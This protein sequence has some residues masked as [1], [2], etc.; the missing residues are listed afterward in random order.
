MDAMY[1]QSQE[2]YRIADRASVGYPMR[3]TVVCPSTPHGLQILRRAAE[4][5]DSLG[6]E[7]QLFVPIV[8]PYP[9]PLDRAPVDL[10]FVARMIKEECMRAGIRAKVDLRLC[11]DFA[12]CLRFGLA[13]ESMVVLQRPE[14]WAWREKMLIRTLRRDGHQ[15]IAL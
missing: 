5:V 4:L 7:I 11:R 1:S 9:L 2:S 12:E 14:P 3:L 15:V 6:A 8:T 13:A 10:T